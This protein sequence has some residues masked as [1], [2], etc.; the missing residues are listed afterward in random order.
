MGRIVRV[1]HHNIQQHVDALTRHDQITVTAA[2]MDHQP[3]PF[4]PSVAI[5]ETCSESRPPSGCI[6]R[7]WTRCGV[8][9]TR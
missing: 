8:G 7:N 9:G 4:I 1:Q 3:V 2:T 6:S 5:A